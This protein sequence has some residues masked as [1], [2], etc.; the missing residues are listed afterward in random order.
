MKEIELTHT[1]VGSTAAADNDQMNKKL[2]SKAKDSWK[3]FHLIVQNKVNVSI[4]EKNE[5]KVV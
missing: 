3:D 4:G 5:S 2:V 1:P